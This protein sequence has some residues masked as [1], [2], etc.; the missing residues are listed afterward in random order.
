MDGNA[1]PKVHLRQANA[2]CE[3]PEWTHHNQGSPG[4]SHIGRIH[5][6]WWSHRSF[7]Y[8]DEFCRGK[9]TALAAL[10]QLSVVSTVQ[11]DMGLGYTW[12]RPPNAYSSTSI[13]AE[14]KK[15][16]KPSKTSKKGDAY[17][18]NQK[19]G[20]HRDNFLLLQ[21]SPLE[22]PIEGGRKML[23]ALHGSHDM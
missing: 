23:E 8:R 20:E 22:E 11:L 9:L 3:G 13:P 1:G 12:A 18:S 2:S 4:Y 5:P 6:V 21:G 16:T 10:A 14:E 19:Y 7:R 17:V 15:N